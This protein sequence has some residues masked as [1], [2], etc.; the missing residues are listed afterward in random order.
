MNKNIWK[1]FITTTIV[2]GVLLAMFWLPRIKVGDKE[3]RRINILSDIERRDSEGNI[4]AEVK[5]D[6]AQGIEVAKFDSS[7]VKVKKPVYVDSI[8]EGMTGIEDFA[9]N[10]NGDR[11]M[12]KFYAAL[13]EVKERPV[14]IA[15]YGDSYIEGDILT[16]DLRD[17]LQ[18]KFGGNGV[19]FVDIYTVTSGFRKTVW[20]KAKGWND[21]NAN[22][23][24]GKQFNK[25]LQGISGRYFI[26]Q[27]SAS[28]EM[29][30]SKYG[31]HLDTM[32][33]ATVFFTPGN[34]LQLATS[35]NGEELKTVYA[36]GGMLETHDEVRYVTEN[37]I[38]GGGV[39]SLGNA[40]PADTVK[41]THEIHNDVAEQSTSGLV[42]KTFRGRIGRF[43]LQAKNGNASRFYGVALEGN[44]GIVL[45]NFSMRASNGWFIGDIPQKTLADFAKKRPYD[46]IIVHFGL[47]V[48]NSKQKDY[49][50]YT[51]RMA[52]SIA[53]LKAQFPHA[54]IL[55]IG[56]GDREEKDIDGN[57]HTM[58]G[59][60]ELI[61]YQRKMAADNK[62]AFWNLYEAMGGD[63]SISL[64]V[65]HKQANLDYTHINFAGGKKLARILYDV[66]LNGKDNYDKRK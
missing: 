24:K 51:K 12:D 63:G 17:L 30:G 22:D 2:I 18:T 3:L 46:L 25:S 44:N 9:D 13:S 20:T 49:S 42:S 43:S 10:E 56:V 4:L 32:Q 26:P 1:P 60:R 34:G 14:R 23:P 66:L 65:T 62:V 53:H 37:V 19:G 54:S 41:V 7:A 50:G 36:N 27:S 28:L 35:I 48:A 38:K 55:V 21:H 8:P 58:P 33:T 6:E 29:K 11:E 57:L 15:Y 40:I 39:D 61:S 47:N 52:T 5:A 31:T 16:E 64:M 45:D 59:V